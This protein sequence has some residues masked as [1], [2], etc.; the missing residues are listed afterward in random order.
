MV[1]LLEEPPTQSAVSNWWTMIMGD[2]LKYPVGGGPSTKPSYTSVIFAGMTV[3]FSIISAVSVS[4]WVLGSTK[5]TI[6]SLRE[7]VSLDHTETREHID[8]MIGNINS[9]SV[10]ESSLASQVDALRQAIVQE[11]QDRLDSERRLYGMPRH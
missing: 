6:D 3:L 5:A 7:L 8:A 10:A 9:L 2:I 11:R 1:G 4:G